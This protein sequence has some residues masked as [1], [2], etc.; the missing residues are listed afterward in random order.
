MFH[1][2]HLVLLK[3]GNHKL[4]NIRAPEV[5]HK[6][7]AQPGPPEAGRFLFVRLSRTNKKNTPLLCALCVSV[8]KPGL[9]A[10]T[11]N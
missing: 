2:C 7:T 8:V 4:A 11:G 9:D 1:L 5:G 6:V 10:F 3:S